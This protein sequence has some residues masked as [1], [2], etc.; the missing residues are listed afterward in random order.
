M[1]PAS[2]PQA[3]WQQELVLWKTIFPRTW[4][5]GWFQDDL[6]PLHLL[7]TLFLLLLHQLHLRSSGIRSRRLGTPSL[8]NW[9]SRESPRKWGECTLKPPVVPHL[10]SDLLPVSWNDLASPTGPHPTGPHLLCLVYS[11]SAMLASL[12]HKHSKDIH[13]SGPLH[14]LFPL[15]GTCFPRVT[16]FALSSFKSLSKCPSA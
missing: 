15:L 1:P 12:F 14:L 2:G 3:F 8:D 4:V 6:I 5:R 7:C 10:I 11:A 13:A 16:W 9:A